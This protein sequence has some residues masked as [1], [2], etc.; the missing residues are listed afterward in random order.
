MPGHRLETQLG[1]RQE[2]W[3]VVRRATGVALAQSRHRVVVLLNR[4]TVDLKLQFFQL[5]NVCYHVFLVRRRG[6]TALL[7]RDTQQSRRPAIRLDDCAAG[8]HAER[9]LLAAPLPDEC[10]MP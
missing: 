6:Q 4:P 8:K 7:F 10:P 9:D 5:V 1:G 3:K 2:S